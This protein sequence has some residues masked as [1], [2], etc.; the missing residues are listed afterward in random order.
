MNQLVVHVAGRLFIKVTPAKRERKGGKNCNAECNSR[1]GSEVRLVIIVCQQSVKG[2]INSCPFSFQGSIGLDSFLVEAVFI[3]VGI[4]K[5]LPLRTDPGKTDL[6][7]SYH[8][9]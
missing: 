7:N 9:C 3:L 6:D 4:W 2:R 5:V 1:N 8:Y